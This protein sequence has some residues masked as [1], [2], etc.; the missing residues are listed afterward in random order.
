MSLWHATGARDCF[1]CLNSTIG[2]VRLCFSQGFDFSGCASAAADTNRVPM[3]L[4]KV[5]S[6]LSYLIK[7]LCNTRAPA[8]LKLDPSWRVLICCCQ[9]LLSPVC[10]HI[11]LTNVRGCL[12]TPRG[13]FI[14]LSNSI[15]LAAAAVASSN[16][17]R[18]LQTSCSSAEPGGAPPRGLSHGAV[19]G[20]KGG[21]D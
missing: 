20:F 13:F 12:R 5:Y 18:E 17:C 7:A 10:S 6:E 1:F 16:L 19:R 2:R 11:V 9:G 14:L 15:W 4:H 3:T 21:E 8:N